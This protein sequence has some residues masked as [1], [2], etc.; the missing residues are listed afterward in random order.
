MLV[1]LAAFVMLAG[2]S[3]NPVKPKSMTEQIQNRISTMSSYAGKGM[4]TFY[5]GTQPIAYEVDVAYRKPDFYRIA[6]RNESEKV[7]QVI[8]KN[9]Q[10]VFVITPSLQKSF[11][12]QTNWPNNQGQVYLYQSIA[13]FLIRNLQDGVKPK[14]TKGNYLVMEGKSQYPNASLD[15]QKV[16]IHSRTFAPKKVQLIDRQQKLRVAMQFRTFTFNTAFDKDFFT[17]KR[18]LEVYQM[19][20]QIR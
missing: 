3:G 16:W 2:C 14:K 18:S 9:K 19:S 11:R 8:L 6:M 20:R 15:K 10:G 13:Q 12:F 17:K 7:D 5:T 4:L 1:G